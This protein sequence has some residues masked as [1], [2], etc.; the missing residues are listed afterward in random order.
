M[1]DSEEGRESRKLDADLNRHEDS[2]VGSDFHIAYAEPYLL[3]PLWAY[4]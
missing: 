3:G 1:D 4:E 2:P